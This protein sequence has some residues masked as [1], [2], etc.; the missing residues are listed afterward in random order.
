MQENRQRRQPAVSA[1]SNIAVPPNT[2]S[3]SVWCSPIVSMEAQ[4]EAP[5][6]L[7]WYPLARQKHRHHRS[8]LQIQ[9][10]RK[11]PTLSTVA[12]AR[13]QVHDQKTGSNPSPGAKIARDNSL[14]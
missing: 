3:N 7:S 2:P 11:R 5:E 10:K 13:G 14:N 6:P 1:A 12:M 9:A 8:W 4:Q